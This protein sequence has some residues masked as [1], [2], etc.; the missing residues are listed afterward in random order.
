VNF[1]MPQVWMVVPAMS[2]CWCQLILEVKFAPLMARSMMHSSCLALLSCCLFSHPSLHHGLPLSKRQT[3]GF[4]RCFELHLQKW[5][6]TTVLPIDIQ[7]VSFIRGWLFCWMHSSKYVPSELK[8]QNQWLTTHS[9]PL[10]SWFIEVT[11]TKHDPYYITSRWNMWP[12]LLSMHRAILMLHSLASKGRSGS[13]SWQ[14]NLQF[15][16]SVTIGG[17]LCS[18]TSSWKHLFREATRRMCFT[19]LCASIPTHI[20]ESVQNQAGMTASPPSK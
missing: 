16:H 18:F 14:A 10:P 1:L 2:S 8:C 4:V 19:L 15:I 6:E 11:I 12:N 7:I 13:P 5:C 20:S 9:L 3:N 17:T